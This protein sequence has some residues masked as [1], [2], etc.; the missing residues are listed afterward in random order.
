[1]VNI[2]C[3]DRVFDNIEAIIFDKDGT[4]ADSQDYLRLVARKRW[5]MLEPRIAALAP[6]SFEATLFQAWGLRD[7]GLRPTGGHR[8]DP[9]SMLAVAS[10]RENEIV[11]AGYVAAL[12][13]S[14]IEA[15]TIV[16]ESFSLASGAFSHKHELTPLF[17]GVLPLIQTL[18]AAG[19]KLG[20]LS[21]DVLPNIQRFVQQQGLTDYIDFC[22]GA[23]PGLHKPDPQL[24]TLTCAGL[25]V[26][27]ASVL[28]IGD[29][30]ADIEL[31][32]RG[33]A[34]G[35]IGVSWG[36]DQP[37]D[38]PHVDVMLQAID[39]IQVV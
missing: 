21:A 30:S 14:W 18:Q 34:A 32:R 7:D 27:P 5:A 19:L 3:G 26:E 35:A 13:F 4:L 24:L 9:K 15:L 17:P 22:Q 8:V 36:W 39:A 28:V 23:E 1:M 31:A 12:E 11:T 29:S 10:R 33:G 25:G 16:H 2:R 6:I 20:I 37:F 38:L